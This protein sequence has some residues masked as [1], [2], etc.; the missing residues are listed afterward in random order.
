MN[1]LN[2]A[3]DYLILIIKMSTS[4]EQEPGTKSL[5]LTLPLPQQTS[6]CDQKIH[7][8]AQLNDDK[9]KEKI[10]RKLAKYFWDPIESTLMEFQDSHSSPYYEEN[11]D[12]LSKR[13]P[14]SLARTYKIM[15]G[16]ITVVITPHY[17]STRDVKGDLKFHANIIVNRGTSKS[18]A[19]K[20]YTMETRDAMNC[21]SNQIDTAY[22][23]V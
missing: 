7:T 21:L 4:L 19:S 20:L 22:E 3:P 14:E 6:V 2:Q 12:I 10:D 15:S 11:N 9:D 17:F 23:M 16:E 18:K 1:L 5:T 13:D 8:E